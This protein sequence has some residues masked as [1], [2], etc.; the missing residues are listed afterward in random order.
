MTRGTV[1][2]YTG[3]MFS[4]KSLSLIERVKE[5]GKSFE[6][7][8]PAIDTRSGNFI[9]SRDASERLAA[10]SIEDIREA[11]DSNADVVV[12]DEAQFFKCVNYK[13]V[14]NSLRDKC[15]IEL[16]GGLD[17]IA[18]GKHWEIYPLILELA[19]E[20]VN[21]T[22]RCNICGGV[23]TYTKKLRGSDA[24]VDIE[25]EGTVFIPVC[26]SCFGVDDNPSPR[27]PDIH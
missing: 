6:C 21:L 16:I 4:G 12:F 27:K 15:K 18:N 5:L 17:R 11:I 25:G 10:N 13:E 22:A 23:A 3:C 1:T 26:A 7:F 24:E 9:V 14:I 19:D 20:V 2:F 8:K